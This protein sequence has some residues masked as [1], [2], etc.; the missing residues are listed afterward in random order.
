MSSPPRHVRSRSRGRAEEE[1]E[2]RWGFSVLSSKE[3][4]WSSLSSSFN[5]WRR[6]ILFDRLGKRRFQVDRMHEL[7]LFT[8]CFVW[9]ST[10]LSL[11]SCI[12]LLAAIGGSSRGGGVEL[13]LGSGGVEL[14]GEVT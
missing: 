11:F 7:S 10:L 6:L 9:P 14:G 2:P 12:F 5:S 1:V 8:A 3:P 4:N 13:G